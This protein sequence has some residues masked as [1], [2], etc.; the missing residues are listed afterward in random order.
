MLVSAGVSW[1]NNAAGGF[2]TLVL[3]VDGGATKTVCVVADGEFRVLGAGLAGPSNY[4][5]VGVEEARKNV[6]LTVKQAV[7]PKPE[8]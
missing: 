4:H 3:G 7:P 8:E 5:V 2:D 1:R 6:D